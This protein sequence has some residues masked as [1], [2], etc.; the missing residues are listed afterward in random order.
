MSGFDVLFCVLMIVFLLAVPARSSCP[1]PYCSVFDDHE[2]YGF[3]DIDAC[4]KQCAVY[5]RF[6]DSCQARLRD[7]GN[8]SS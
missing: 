2:S 1:C 7:D 8:F 5:R 4:R 6:V 3:T